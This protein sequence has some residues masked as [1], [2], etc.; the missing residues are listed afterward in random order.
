MN[1]EYGHEPDVPLQPVAR[2]SVVYNLKKQAGSD[3]PDDKYEEYDPIATVEAVAD[4]VGAYGFSVSLCEQDDDFAA[5]LAE[6]KP[7]FVA[8]IAEGRG[9]ARGR[10]AQVPCFLESAGI[11]YW[12]S[13]AVSMAVALDKL[14]TAG[15]FSAT[16]SPSLCAPVSNRNRTYRNSPRSSPSVPASS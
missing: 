16:R 5:R 11:P 8:N 1:E 13:D 10:E 2:V 12:G 3:E 14:L 6:Q 4:A 15:P 9:E 7:Q